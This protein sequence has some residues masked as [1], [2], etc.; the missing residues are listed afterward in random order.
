MRSGACS[1]RSIC[2]RRSS[3]RA[4]F[5][6][7]TSPHDDQNSATFQQVRPVRELFRTHY[8]GSPDRRPPGVFL[9]RASG[10]RRQGVGR[11]L[12]SGPGFRG[13]GNQRRNRS[14]NRPPI[15]SWTLTT[16][17]QGPPPFANAGRRPAAGSR[18]LASVGTTKGNL[19]AGRMNALFC[20]DRND[21]DA[22]VVIEW[23]FL[24]GKVSA[25]L[26]TLGPA[27][28]HRVSATVVTVA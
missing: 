1:V 22:S 10:A 6:R 17:L 16:S 19:A 20:F 26:G 5:I 9:S 23:A 3:A 27:R 28:S 4:R 8:A 21:G 11:G 15:R 7:T 25:R 13:V 2:L 12:G 24:S 14:Q 18:S